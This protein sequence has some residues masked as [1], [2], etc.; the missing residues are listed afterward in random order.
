MASRQR[1]CTSKAQLSIDGAGRQQA[2]HCSSCQG[3]LIK[4]NVGGGMTAAQKSPRGKTEQMP[5]DMRTKG[6][7]HSQHSGFFKTH[8]WST[9]STKISWRCVSMTGLR[10]K[11]SDVMTGQWTVSLWINFH[12]FQSVS[13]G[14][15]WLG[16]IRQWLTNLTLLKLNSTAAASEE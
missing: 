8:I 12:V 1:C 6:F 7:S 2:C 5:G 3:D 13:V 9:L 14:T 15:P 10:C 11:D 4:W 16:L